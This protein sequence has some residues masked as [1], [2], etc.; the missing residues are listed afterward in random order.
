MANSSSFVA[1]LVHANKL[2][3]IE[4]DWNATNSVAD[5]PSVKLAE[6]NTADIIADTIEVKPTAKANPGP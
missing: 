1:F 3:L 5:H 6:P 4:Y 2:I